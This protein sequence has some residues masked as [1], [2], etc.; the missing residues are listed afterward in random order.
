MGIFRAVLVAFIG[1]ISLGAATGHAETKWIDLPV[2]TGGSV[3]ALLGIPDGASM[4]PGVVYSHG[5]F[6][7]RMGYEAAKDKGYDVAEYVTALNAAGYVA[8]APVRDHGVLSDPDSARRGDVGREPTPSLQAGIEQGIASLRA[9]VA[10]LKDH[11]TATGKVG[12]VG[13]SEG[14]LVTLWTLLDGLRVD[15][16]VLMSPATIKKARRLNM[17]NALQSGGFGEIKAPVL[18]TLGED[19]NA[20]ILRVVKGRLIPA[21]R[22]AGVSVETKLDYPG[23]HGWFWQVR[24]AHFADMRSFLDTRLK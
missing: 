11:A 22:E 1:M 24:S 18:V 21:M 2:S 8:L 6:V 17:K 3:K 19:D 20:P 10:Y 15:A 12:A 16:A 9:A 14:G 13:F 4:A 23:D 7:R 5:T